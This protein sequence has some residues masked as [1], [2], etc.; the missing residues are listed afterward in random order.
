MYGSK[1][2]LSFTGGATRRLDS[3]GQKTL[4]YFDTMKVQQDSVQ[5]TTY[6]IFEQMGN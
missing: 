5:Q 3:S 4:P 1:T 6:V 2:L